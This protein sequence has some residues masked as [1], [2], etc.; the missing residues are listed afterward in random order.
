MGKYGKIACKESRNCRSETWTPCL[1]LPCMAQ[2]RMN[3]WECPADGRVVK[4]PTQKA[5]A[6]EYHGL[7]P[8]PKSKPSKPPVEMKDRARNLQRHLNLCERFCL[9]QR[10]WRTLQPA[11]YSNL[12]RGYL[13]LN[14]CNSPGMN[15]FCKTQTLK[16]FAQK[17]CKTSAKKCK[18]VQIQTTLPLNRKGL[19]THV[20][21]CL[22]E[23]SDTICKEKCKI[24]AC[25][26]LWRADFKKRALVPSRA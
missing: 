17:M 8:T 26:I 13:S 20:Y 1:L 2:F 7:E 23:H 21:L 19:L 14:V 24:T 9:Q 18:R 5:R 4:C 22:S 10:I 16:N 11:A 15:I 25:K 12:S 6:W 3:L